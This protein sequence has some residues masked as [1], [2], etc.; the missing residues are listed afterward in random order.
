M[1]R[2]AKD[3]LPARVGGPW[4]QEKL[5][6][7][8]KY[9]SAFMVAMAPKRKQGKWDS[10]VYLDLLAGPGRGIDVK[11]GAEFDGSPLRALKIQPRFDRLFFA[12]LKLKNIEALRQRIP[13]QDSSRVSIQCGNCNEL[14]KEIVR[15]HSTRTLGLAFVD[16]EGFEAKFE[17]FQALATRRIDA[18]LLFP[19]GGIARNLHLFAK[20]SNS[21][22]DEF[23]GGREWRDLPEMKAAAGK[24]LRQEEIQSLKVPLVGRFRARMADIGFR[25]QDEHDPRLRNKKNVP[26]YHLLYFSKD[27]AGL[28]IWQGIKKIEPSGQRT[29][30]FPS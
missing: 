5:T 18:L 10:L 1:I 25:H 20:M 23:L 4:T 29:L 30:S 11:S 16:P 3:G 12:D 13:E 7:V 22:L 15:Q 27:S 24:K 28:K 14:A 2:R 19:T 17:M 26:M 6:Y 8:Q 21:P 9:A